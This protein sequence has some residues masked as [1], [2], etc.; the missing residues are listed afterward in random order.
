MAGNISKEGI[1][2]DLEWMNRVGIGGVQVFDAGM[3]VGQY[4]DHRIDFMTPE[5]RDMLRHAAAECDRLGLEMGMHSSAGWSETGGPWVRPEAAMKKYVWSETRVQG[6]ASFDDVL[7]RPPSSNGRFQ[8]LDRN[9]AGPDP[10]YYADSAV[11]AYRIARDETRM[12]DAQPQVTLSSGVADA[13][14]MLDHDLATTMA[15]LIPPPGQRAWVQF[16][17]ARPY[18]ARALSIAVRA[19]GVPTG[20]LRV[21]GDGKDFRTLVFLPGEDH[22]PVPAHT[23]TFPETAARFYR[24]EFSAPAPVKSYEKAPTEYE[25]AELDLEC[26]ARVNRWEDKA[27]FSALYE[28]ESLSTPPAEGAVARADVIDLTSRMHRDGR[29]E[30]DVP[31]GSWVIL[32]LGY[33]LTGRKNAPAVETGRGYEVDKLNRQY[34]ERYFNS[35]VGQIRDALGPLFGKSFRNLVMDSWEAGFLNWT[36]DMLAEFRFRRGYNPTPYLPVLTGR[37]VENA[38]ASDRFL[39]DFRRTLADLLAENHYGAFTESANRQGLNVYA[40]AAGIYLPVIQDGLANKGRVDIPMGEFWFVDQKP[41]EIRPEDESDIREAASAAHIYGKRLAAAESFTTPRTVPGWAQPPSYLKWLGDR[42]MAAGVNRIVFHTSVHQP[43]RDRKPGITMSSFGQH[44]TRNITWAELAGPFMRYLS[45]SSYMLQQGLFVGDL[46]YYYGEGAPAVIPYWQ[47]LSPKAPT[48]YDY[49][50][51]NTEVLL[52]RLSVADGHLMLPDGMSY[53]VL[54]LPE[55]DRM[56]PQVLKKIRDL[57]AGG[58]TVVGPKPN[59]SPS[60]SGYP[61]CDNE[62]SSLATELWGDIDGRSITERVYGNGKV[63]W[64]KP[65]KD[66][67]AEQGVG[68]DFEYTRPHIDTFLVSI[69]RRAGDADIYFVANQRDRVEDLTALFRVR[70]KSAELW[71]PDTGDIE[72]APYNMGVVQTGVPLHLDPFGSVFVV[73]RHPASAT[74]RSRERP[75]PV[76]LG[77]LSGPWQVAFP[78]NWGAPS[79]IRFDTLVSWSAHADEGVKYFSGTATYSKDFDVPKAWLQAPSRHVLDLGRVKE[80]AEV[81]LNGKPLGILWKAPFQADVTQALR[82]GPNHLEI[83]ITNLWPNRIIGDEQP[84]AQRKY[85]FTAYKVFTKDSPLLESGL[86]GPVTV[87]SVTLQS[88]RR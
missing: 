4:V 17:F 57:V 78:P 42:A 88:G 53:R 61:V 44:L 72:P 26:G 25:I 36:D 51:L 48:G 46:L 77:T 75:T 80:F 83:R 21:S 3:G 31:G 84:S 39:W 30:W 69:H 20:E 27:G 33:S 87:N 10:T 64:G 34:V 47:G 14:P 67:L 74:S 16:E 65:L 62:V 73:F 55:S 54:V 71:H 28:Y 50:V 52:T 49:D 1:T 29:L 15:L 81:F 82:I 24:V 8:N 11:I 9:T 12:S 86:L 59:R 63:V 79:K 6:P 7:P 60:L 68:P 56:T 58:A 13:S 38:D 37:V 43:L 40:E 45:R 23:Y 19:R 76:V 18:R 66:V 5:W 32:R 70:G 85:T 2:L 22:N 35:Y 41:G